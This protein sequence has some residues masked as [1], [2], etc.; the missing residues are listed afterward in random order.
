[1]KKIICSFLAMLLLCVG[2]FSL[3]SCG[4]G[5]GNG[6][7]IE[8]EIDG[9][10]DTG[11]FNTTQAQPFPYNELEV[12][13]EEWEALNPGYTVNLRRVSYGGDQASLIPLLKARKAPDIIYQNGSVKESHIGNN[14][15]VPYND[16]LDKPNPYN[17]N[18]PWRE[19]YQATELEAT[20]A[21]DGN[22]YYMNLER[23]A[24]GIL[25]N[26]TF[27]EEH[28][29]KVPETYGEF[30]EVQ[31]QIHDL[32]KIPYLAQYPWYN[33]ILE[34]NIFSDL[35]DDL[36]T[37]R[38]NGVVDMEEM[39]RGYKKGIWTPDCEEYGRY[40][41][42]IC[43]KAQYEPVGG[44]GYDPITSFLRGDTIMIEAT[45]ESMRKAHYNTVKGFEEGVTEMVHGQSGLDGPAMPEPGFAPEKMSA[46]QLLIKTIEE[47]EEKI[48]LVPTGPLTN[49]AALFLVRPDLKEKI[50]RI[51]L[52]GGGAY[53]GNWT[54]AA[55]YNIYV[56]PEAASIVFNSGVPIVMAGLDV[57]HQAY[58]TREENE[59]LRQ[60]GGRIAVFAAELIDFFS[61][62]H[63]EVEKLPGCTI[64]DACAVAYLCHP[65]IFVE[66]QCHVDIELEGSLT[67]GTTVCDPGNYEGKEKNA[68]V[69]YGVDRE[70][71]AELFIEAMSKLDK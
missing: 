11:N 9:G 62:Y 26:K 29:L 49:I 6:N 14:Y 55:E 22:Y 48:T 69:L 12:L 28:G 44:A 56:D 8:I 10:G 68:T 61:R 60:K 54:P 71:F 38:P 67:A 51:S 32:G 31:K 5:G 24:A 13:L 3:I 4:D 27:F 70:K 58:I 63:Y 66:K 46:L 2:C 41:D 34:T 45:G 33:I 15:Y 23:L 53:T 35:I 42:L 36:D 37:I 59:I 25:Y 40:L 19:V 64:H 18:K 39:V 7:V 20:V 43:E 16:Y 17:D 47:S 21:S 30:M 57:T 65:E 1:M 52:M 50:E